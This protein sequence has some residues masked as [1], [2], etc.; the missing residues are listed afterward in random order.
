M[1]HLPRQIREVD[2]E[3]EEE[4]NVIVEVFGDLEDG[5]EHETY[6]V[7]KWDSYERKFSEGD[8]TETLKLC[9]VEKHHSLWGNFI[10]NTVRELSDLIDEGKF[11]IKDKSAIEYLSFALI[12]ELA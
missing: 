3:D 9:L 4:E 10:Y 12:M 1:R 8:P 11:S 2:V 7:L 6:T 5:S